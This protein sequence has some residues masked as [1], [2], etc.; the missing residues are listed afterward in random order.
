MR[1]M[2]SFMVETEL[3]KNDCEEF[4]KNESKLHLDLDSDKFFQIMKRDYGYE[5]NTISRFL[6]GGKYTPN[7]QQEFNIIL[8]RM[9]R[10]HKIDIADSI[11]FLEDSILLSHILKFIDG[12]TEWVL[13]EELMSRCNIGKSTNKLFEFLY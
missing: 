5:Y 7:E 12:E 1:E 2:D 10:D 13:K 9:K 3:I 4:K 11:M 6:E 8:R